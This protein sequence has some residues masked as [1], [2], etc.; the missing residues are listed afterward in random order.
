MTDVA[1]L[2]AAA[3]TIWH[4][5]ANREVAGV[6]RLLM[7]RP[8]MV[9]GR[10][11][12]T[13]AKV[14]L[15]AEALRDILARLGWVL[16]VERDLV[17]LRKSP[18]DRRD[19]Y[20]A[21]GPNPRTCQWFFCFVAAAESMGRRVTLGTFV[22]AAQ[23]AAAEAGIAVTGDMGE[24]HARFAALRMLT[25]RGVIE[26][27]D[28]TVADYLH[29]EDPPVLL[30]VHHTRLL[31]V[32][33]N[34]SPDH[35][36]ANE[37]EAWLEAVERESNV[38]RR[39]RR[40]LVDGTLVHVSDL[41]DAEADWMSRR[42]RDDG[43]PLAEAFGLH[44]E[45]RSEGAAFVVSALDANPARNLGPLPFPASGTVAHAALLVC[46]W[47]VA[48]AVDAPERPGWRRVADAALATKLTELAE[49]QQSGSGGWSAE[50]AADPA[51]RLRAEVVAF[52]QGLDLVRADGGDWLFSPAIA[53]WP[54]PR[55][56]VRRSPKTAAPAPA[57]LFN[58]VLE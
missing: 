14:R 46:N 51:G 57:G 52:L 26:E 9:A 20:A 45:R 22:A 13:I 21:A 25:A 55:P 39:M 31:H 32:I 16:V 4:P 50:L 1:P 19:A 7:L 37:P 49:A 8:W 10:D 43:A 24:R 3:R 5:E 40:R 15:H 53:R 17:R 54:A 58:G 28:G 56:K 34:Y 30:A 27:L 38:A 6:L 23:A 18:P 41:D 44:L 36:P 33:A 2:K 11:D 12:D 35:D 47:M 48:A 29:D 42:L